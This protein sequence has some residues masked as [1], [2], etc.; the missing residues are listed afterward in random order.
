LM[1]YQRSGVCNQQTFMRRGK[2]SG[3]PPDD[4]QASKRGVFFS[5]HQFF[6]RHASAD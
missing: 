3:K 4:H 1:G 6:E 2:R 5:R